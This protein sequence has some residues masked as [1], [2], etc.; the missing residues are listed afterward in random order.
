[1]YFRPQLIHR[2]VGSC[3]PLVGLCRPLLS[4]PSMKHLSRHH[5][6]P[7][8]PLALFSEQTWPLAS[9]VD[10]VRAI[11][12]NYPSLRL[13]SG[14]CLCLCFFGSVRPVS[15]RLSDLPVSLCQLSLSLL[16]RVIWY[17][18]GVRGALKS[19]SKKLV[20]HCATALTIPLKIPLTITHLTSVSPLSIGY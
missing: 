18:A 11:C 2:K 10:V 7:S 8:H 9:A 13:R 16:Y 20:G 12:V 17:S 1:M 5:L 15:D 4:N 6:F 14:L 3:L 19:D